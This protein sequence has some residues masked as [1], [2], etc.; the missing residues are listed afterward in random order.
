MKVMTGAAPR[1][2]DERLKTFLKYRKM[3]NKIIAN[4]NDNSIKEADKK[5]LRRQL[6]V[7]LLSY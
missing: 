6:A 3:V 7:M 5:E 1:Y 2:N 4:I